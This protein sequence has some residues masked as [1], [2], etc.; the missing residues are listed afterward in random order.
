MAKNTKH[1]EHHFWSIA[2]NLHMKKNTAG[3]SNEL[4]LSVLDGLK[5]QADAQDGTKRSKSVPA[6][7]GGRASSRDGKGAAAGTPPLALPAPASLKE[8]RMQRARARALENPEEE[9]QRRKKRRRV[10]RFAMGAVALSCCVAL[11]ATGVLFA[12]E[13][14]EAHDQTM[15]VLQEGF[16]ELE[17]ADQTILAA[18]A[19]VTSSVDDS[20]LD[21]ITRIQ[22]ELSAAGVHVNAAESLA[23]EAS[24]RLGE[25]ADRDAANQLAL[26]ASSRRDMMEYAAALMEQDWHA[27]TAVD[28]VNA[29][30][31]QVLAADALMKEAAG[32]VKDTTVENTRASQA[33][34][35][36]ALAKLDEAMA[37]LNVAYESYNA[38]DL[39]LLE[40]YIVKRQEAAYF[41]LASDEAIY[42]QD[43][44]TAE[45][46]NSA[47]NRAEAEAAAIAGDFPE[48]PAQPILDVYE[49]STAP[50]RESYLSARLSAGE[51]DAFI[52]D[53]LSS[54]GQ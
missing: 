9:I 13:R 53:Y 6:S 21:E 28:A 23:A 25:S 51:A 20:T 15:A 11:A 7:L 43:K 36:E 27:K 31:E 32:L 42:V 50:L 30:W 46:S 2:S 22:E 47:Y 38:A 12:S 40:S 52:R 3:T 16:E 8:S 26:S 35:E 29:C 39:G 34:T 41:A 17:Q 14:L 45:E 1:G 49:A 4:S 37:F 44:A 18:D 54:N 10:R 33:K 48:D 5:S 19:V 24:K